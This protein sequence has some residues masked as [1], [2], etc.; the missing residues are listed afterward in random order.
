MS[1]AITLSRQLG[2][3]GEEIA[4]GIAAELGLRVIG[5]SHV[6]EAV[7]GCVLENPALEAAEE[8]PALV[9]RVLDFVQGKPAIPTSLPVF[10]L[11]DSGVLSGGFFK[12]GDYYKSALESIVFELTQFGGVLILGQAS[13]MILRDHPNAFHMRVVAPRDKRIEAVQQQLGVGADQARQKV[14]AFDKARADYLRRHY[15]VDIDDSRLY[16][17]TLNTATVPKD[18]VVNLVVDTVRSVDWA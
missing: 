9:R 14:D 6:H 10:S 15:K 18:V 3:G 17:L 2:A 16:D 1:I 13:Q 11:S 4:C 5:R 12:N 8:R 7:E